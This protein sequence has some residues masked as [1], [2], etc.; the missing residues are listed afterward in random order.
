MVE[1][2]QEL[3][4]GF[5]LDSFKTIT[6]YKQAP[7]GVICLSPKKQEKFKNNKITADIIVEIIFKPR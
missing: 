5:S 6:R 4:Q 3:L 7:R 1:E 2:A